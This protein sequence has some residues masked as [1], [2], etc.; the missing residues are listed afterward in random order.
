MGIPI[1]SVRVETAL[2]EKVSVIVNLT[3]K[4]SP[5]DL[6]AG[7]HQAGHI[8]NILSGEPELAV[9]VMNRPVEANATIVP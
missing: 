2:R 6:F 4:P 8:K 9:R 5:Q 1:G 3:K 7:S